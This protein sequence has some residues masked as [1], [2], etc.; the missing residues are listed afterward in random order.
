MLN[1]KTIPDNRYKKVGKGDCFGFLGKIHIMLKKIKKGEVLE[2]GVRR[3]FVLV[4]KI[5]KFGLWICYKIK[6]VF[7][8][9]VGLSLKNLW[10]TIAILSLC[11]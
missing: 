10:R 8:Q 7:N 5:S 6:Y 3:D 9:S 1:A 4:L 2:P 11:Q